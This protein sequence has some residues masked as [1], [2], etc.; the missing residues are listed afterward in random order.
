MMN[1][2]LSL[3]LLYFVC[4]FLFSVHCKD[5]EFCIQNDNGTFYST[6]SE[7]NDAN[8]D[9]REVGFCRDLF[10]KSDLIAPLSEI[11]CNLI[12]PFPVFS[13]FSDPFF[14]LFQVMVNLVNLP[15][16]VHILVYSLQI[17]VSSFRGNFAL[18]HFLHS[19]TMSSS[20]VP[21]FSFI[22]HSIHFSF[23]SHS[24]DRFGCYIFLPLYRI[25]TSSIALPC[26]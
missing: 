16:F 22:P 13:P 8:W 26:T 4:G 12:F 24:L 9:G 18:S 11:S 19:F 6:Y 15:T 17:A 14:E 5:S 7:L 25:N 23:T 21:C 10:Q 2:Q 3:L 20:F 1:S